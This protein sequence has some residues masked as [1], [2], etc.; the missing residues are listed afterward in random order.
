MN[1]HTAT[2]QPANRT[3]RVYFRDNLLLKT[4]AVLELEER[5]GDRT[6]PVVPYFAPSAASSL[7]L[8]QSDNVSTCPLKG[9]A[10]YYAYG[11]VD[12]AIWSY[13]RPNPSVSAIAGYLG[14]D[15]SKGFRV[16]AD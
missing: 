10:S 9:Q 14:F 6:M 16:E 3:Y 11:G 8:S 1:D 7:E 15:T 5:F 13:P 4:D 2:I 12:D